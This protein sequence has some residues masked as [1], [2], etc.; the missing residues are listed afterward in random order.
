MAT[1]N[2]NPTM[3]RRLIWHRRDLRIRDNELYQT[4]EEVKK[5]YSIFIF[6]P[7]DYHPQST[8]ISNDDK[9][10]QL[11]GVT[12]GP[13][14]TS[15]L[16]HA[17]HSLKRNLQS[18][19]G[20]LLVRTGNPVDI[21]PQITKELQIDEVVWS[22]TPGYYEY[23][24]S[25]K[26]KKK[27]LEEVQC[28]IYTTCSLTLAHPKDLPTDQIVWQ[29]LA[30]PKEKR[31]KKK[32]K[33]TKQQL[34]NNNQAV[35]TINY[36]GVTATTTNISPSR[37]VGMPQ[38]MGDFRRVARNAVI[39][40]LYNAPNPLHIGII[41]EDMDIGA[42]PPLQSLTQPLLESTR[43]ILGCLPKEIIEQLVK[44]A[45]DNRPD[46][47]SIDIE[48]QSH[49]HLQ[50]FIHHH[51]ATADRALCDV[52]DNNSSMLS[53][54]LALGILSPQQVYHY[55]KQH[56]EKMA[57]PDDINW[58]ISHMEMRDFFIYDS[59][60]NGPA[61]YQLVPMKQPVHKADD[62]REWLPLSQHQDGFIR[63]A[64]GKTGLPMVD[65][66]MRELIT[67][68]YTS[69]RVRQNMASVL[70]KDLKLDWRLG[71]EFFQLCLAD[72]C[73]AAN[74][75]NWAYFAGVG[76][77]SKSRHFRTVSQSNRYDPEGR[78]VR[79]WIKQLQDV[80]EV[81]AILRPWDFMADWGVPIVPPTTQITW[82]DKEKLERSGR[83]SIFILHDEDVLS[84]QSS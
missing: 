53:M 10:E 26:M 63:W 2:N 9:S 29:T 11:Y 78:Y 8:G 48:E 31:K 13:H 43:P 74:Y 35:E 17:V 58:L 61:A 49:Q 30:R 41:P 70:T 54:P 62:K 7:Q 84:S 72:H 64:S 69:N 52:S 4:N 56:Q 82:N 55:I 37:F 1:T 47:S 76:G 71:A 65:A 14:F 68:G 44:C 79:K 20:D 81:E 80:K 23:V 15:R 5:I 67:T 77:D 60:R 66:G 42:I 18:M 57:S 40:D 39:R 50:N 27:L 83:I 21:I 38:I 45:T 36:F 34:S 33:A 12:N 19:G 6:N 59:L 75:G 16:L 3:I 46:Y 51:A 25:E 73:V 28:N 24:Q 32:S 22:E